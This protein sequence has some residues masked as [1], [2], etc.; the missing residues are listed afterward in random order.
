MIPQAYITGWRKK[1]PW[2]EDFQVEQDLIIER[3]LI[4]IYSDDFLRER[5]A[6]RGGTALHKL[7]LAPQARYSEDIDLVQI[8]SEPIKDT[9]KAL[10][11]C[12]AFIDEKP[13][14]RQKA[15]NNT[16]LFRFESEGGIPLRLKVETNCREHFTVN[17]IKEIKVAVDSE[18]FKG[19]SIVL[20]YDIHEML[21]TKLRA[22]YQRKKGRDLFDMWYAMTQTKADGAAIIDVWKKYMAEEGNSVSRKEFINNMDR[23]VS[24]KEFTGDI[25]GLL[26]PGIVFDP[27][28][29]YEYVKTE[30]LEKI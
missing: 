9:L 14:V 1:V 23:K 18:W 8:K 22:L 29:S 19:A 6:F 28:I 11:E 30:L 7:Y 25:Q 17:G 26:R 13:V 5:L 21:G 16:M 20:T 4:E 3:S 15:N 24:D 10:R 27:N 2:Q 12:L